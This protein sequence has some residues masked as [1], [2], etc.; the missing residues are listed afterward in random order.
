MT[1]RCV[2]V[3]EFGGPEV[4][5][6]ERRAD[7]P[8][9]GSGQVRIAL[10]SIGL[11]HAELM[12]REG[13][14]KLASGDPPF[15]PGLEGGGVI[16]AVGDGVDAGRFGERVSLSPVVT[17]LSAGFGGTYR[18]HY[19]CPAVDALPAPPGVPDDQLGALWLPYLTAWGC[20]VWLHGLDRKPGQTVAI[21]AAS[22]SVGL[23]AAQVVRAHGGTPIGLTTRPGKVSLIQEL[24]ESGFEH[25]LATRDDSGAEADWRKRLKGLTGGRGVDVFFDPVA[26]G[27]YLST[28]IRC[29]APGGAVYVYGLLGEPGPVDVF[30]LIRL[31]A[32]V[33]GYVNGRLETADEPWRD[34]CRHVFDGFAQGRYR[35]HIGGRW[36]LEDVAQAHEAMARGGHVGKLLLVP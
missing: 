20:L 30:P 10:T 4:F 3:P 24:P 7:P 14:Y 17:R 6:V 19:V 32:K 31:G 13:R 33:E 22:S 12:A 21:P 23:A 8:E 36:A 16:D 15:V 34:G 35:Q 11:N 1:Y 26:A 5:H 28:E 27:P 29:L 9:P 25:V 18:S 2:R